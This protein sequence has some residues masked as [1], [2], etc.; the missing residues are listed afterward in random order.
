MTCV[1][2]VNAAISI[3]DFRPADGSVEAPAELHQ[4]RSLTV[5]DPSKTSHRVSAQG[6]MFLVSPEWTGVAVLG[7]L[8]AECW[9]ASELQ[10][11]LTVWGLG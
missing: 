4:V 1:Y 10:E 5:S 2:R 8:P 11:T 3:E 7:T 9:A 6:D